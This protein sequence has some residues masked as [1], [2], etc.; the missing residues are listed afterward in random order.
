MTSLYYMYYLFSLA[1]EEI[2]E[3]INRL[4]FLPGIPND[5]RKKKICVD[6][7]KECYMEVEGM[8]DIYFII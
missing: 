5:K 1:D 3:S 6:F 2:I 7:F 8:L 4:G